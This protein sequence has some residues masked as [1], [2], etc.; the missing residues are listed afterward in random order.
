VVVIVASVH[1]FLTF[2]NIPSWAVAVGTVFLG[3]ATVRLGGKAQKE[4]DAVAKQAKLSADQ[5]DLTRQQLEAAQRPFVVPIT[6]GWGRGC[7]GRVSA[8]SRSP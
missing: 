1:H 6:E 8:S 2:W 7:S 5:L 4:A 3:A